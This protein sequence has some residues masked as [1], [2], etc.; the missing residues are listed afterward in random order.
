MMSIF[1]CPSVL[2]VYF[3]LLIHFLVTCLFKSFTH[4]YYNLFS[5]SS[6]E[7]L[8]DAAYKLFI[9]Y[10]YLQIISVCD[11]HFHSFNNVFLK[12]S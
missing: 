3:H 5:L 10:D 8:L 9:S 7:F 1:S 12:S 6:L 2:C 4:F 11:L